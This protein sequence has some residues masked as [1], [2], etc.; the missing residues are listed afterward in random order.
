MKYGK[1][2]S[3]GN[4]I[5]RNKDYIV[6]CSSPLRVYSLPAR[7]LSVFTV[8]LA[9]R[10]A[11]FRQIHPCEPLYSSFDSTTSLDSLPSRRLTLPVD[12][13]SSSRSSSVFS[14]HSIPFP[15]FRH[16]FLPDES[17]TSPSS[18][19]DP[20]S[21]SKPSQ[22]VDAMGEPCRVCGERV[23]RRRYDRDVEGRGK[24]EFGLEL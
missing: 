12:S 4:G 23:D 6:S 18:R 24:M 7:I 9:K 22:N 16:L 15:T 3:D 10:I 5:L 1:G 8:D 20:L 13:I 11:T 2:H 19:C 17:R 14:S 21:R